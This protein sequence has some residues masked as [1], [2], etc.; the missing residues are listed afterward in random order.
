MMDII[1]QERAGSL[2]IVRS[3]SNT[4]SRVKART[5]SVWSNSSSTSKHTSLIEQADPDNPGVVHSLL[6][7]QAEPLHNV[8]RPTIQT[9]TSFE[10]NSLN[11][12]SPTISPAAAAQKSSVC[13]CK[14][15]SQAQ[16]RIAPNTSSSIKSGEK[17]L[18]NQNVS[19]TSS[20]TSSSSSDWTSSSLVPNASMQFPVGDLGK[21][22]TN[23]FITSNQMSPSQRASS[24][25]PNH[26]LNDS[27]FQST[28]LSSSCQTNA[29]CATSGKAYFTI[30]RKL[31]TI[32]QELYKNKLRV[33]RLLL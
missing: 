8:A 4:W 18:V 23:I 5:S 6:A 32:V 26:S 3:A 21:E 10:P 22:T 24:S 13:T 2:S 19:Q 31:A 7:R 17:N 1:F 27:S 28:F 15:P 30:I 14:L 25:C 29:S 16:L 20:L 33:A 9:S 11:P 12:I